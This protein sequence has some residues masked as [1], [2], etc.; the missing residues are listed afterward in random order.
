MGGKAF[1]WHFSLKNSI[2]ETLNSLPYQDR[3]FVYVADSPVGMNNVQAF[4]DEIGVPLNDAPGFYAKMEEWL[5]EIEAATGCKIVLGTYIQGVGN[6]S[7]ETD[8]NYVAA[9]VADNPTFT[10]VDFWNE[11]HSRVNTTAY[12]FY[13]DS[14]HQTSA[15]S[16][17][18]AE[19]ITSILPHPNMAAAPRFNVAAPPVI[20]GTQT[21]GSVLSCST[22]TPH[23]AG[24]SYTYQW[25]RNLAVI[26]GAT[27]SNYTLQAAD[28]GNRV[29]CRVTAVK[30]GQP[31]ASFTAAPTGVIA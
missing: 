14:I 27:S 4:W 7:A 24:D 1:N 15:G 30:S 5:L 31:S 22:G 6:P 18:Q 23:V 8:R 21:S 2:I 26:A 29:A 28:V 25:L 11:P 12:G 13:A 3:Y 10:L 19:F 16:Q 20:T 17:V 9:I